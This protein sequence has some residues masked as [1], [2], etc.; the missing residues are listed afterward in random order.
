[1]SVQAG[2]Y[3]DPVDGGRWR[4]FD[5]RAWTE[6]VSSPSPSPPGSTTTPAWAVVA[7]VPW[8][9]RTSRTRVLVIAGATLAG[10]LAVG[11][12]GSAGAG[13]GRTRAAGTGSGT[14]QD[15]SYQLG[16]KAPPTVS[17]LPRSRSAGL[18][19]VGEQLRTQVDA[20]VPG[21]DAAL[22]QTYGSLSGRR[23]VLV[24]VT[25]RAPIAQKAEGAAVETAF[26]LDGG[27][28]ITR[29]E[30]DD[31]ATQ[32][33]ATVPESND[34]P[35]VAECLWLRSGTGMVRLIEV[36]RDQKAVA[37]D[38]ALALAQIRTRAG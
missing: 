19:A 11:A 7:T 35:A 2:W 36:G 26:S 20:A 17:G 15:P 21:A 18:V 6:H 13:S 28:T 38:L 14:A 32:V 9:R 8:W 4:W 3:A 30:L 22:V 1:M 16:T 37:A 23:A 29:T 24:W 31:G 33:C 10:L 5:G 27:R 25:V 34:T 12:A